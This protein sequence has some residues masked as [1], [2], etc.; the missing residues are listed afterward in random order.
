[1]SGKMDGNRN[2]LD[3]CRDN[4]KRLDQYRSEFNDH[5]QKK[6]RLDTDIANLRGKITFEESELTKILRRIQRI[7]TSGPVC[8]IGGVARRDPTACVEMLL[9]LTGSEVAHNT[10]ISRL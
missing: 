8:I 4:K 10:N 5:I 2:R 3:R 1:M 7:S 6:L 9:D